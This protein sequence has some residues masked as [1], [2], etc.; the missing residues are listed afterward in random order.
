MTGAELKKWRK[1]NG[2]TQQRLQI[3]LGVKSRGTI[4]SWENS[5]TAV[6]RVVELALLA[7]SEIPSSRK[8]LGIVETTHGKAEYK[9]RFGQSLTD[10]K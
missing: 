6:P 10:R 8:A 7:L 2:Y 4:S 9:K 3:E 1:S 5:A